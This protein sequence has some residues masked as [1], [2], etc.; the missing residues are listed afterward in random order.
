MGDEELSPSTKK[1]SL[2]EKDDDRNGERD[3]ETSGL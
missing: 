3:G 1:E 2:D